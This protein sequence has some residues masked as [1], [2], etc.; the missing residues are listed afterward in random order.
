MKI[1]IRYRTKKEIML[2]PVSLFKKL[3]KAKFMIR[4]FKWRII[5]I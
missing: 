2:T 1:L 3:K 5:F 4:L